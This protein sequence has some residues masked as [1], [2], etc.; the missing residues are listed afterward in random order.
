MGQ[1]GNSLPQFS[2]K[3]I[4]KTKGSSFNIEVVA[5]PTSLHPTKVKITALGKVYE[6]TV[7]PGNG[8]TFD[9][10]EC[11]D[12]DWQQE[13]PPH[14]PDRSFPGGHSVVLQLQEGNS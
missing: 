13:E 7:D 10:P 14:C 1:Q 4:L 9:L 8:V 6:K 2:C 12:I 5:P 11:V 3:I